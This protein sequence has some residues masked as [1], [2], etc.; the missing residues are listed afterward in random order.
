[1]S[2]N[3]KRQ[4]DKELR[5]KVEILKAQLSTSSTV[6]IPKEEI[7]LERKNISSSNVETNIKTDDR[8]IKRDLAKTVLLSLLAFSII[9]ALK[10]IN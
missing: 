3:A 6:Y 7:K 5:R 10:L 1:M 2:K 8:L 9:L 4:K